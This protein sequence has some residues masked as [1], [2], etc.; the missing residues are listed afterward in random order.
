MEPT[1]GH[2]DS[3]ENEQESA[4]PTEFGTPAAGTGRTGDER[5]VYPKAAGERDPDLAADPTVAGDAPMGQP[6]TDPDSPTP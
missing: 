1:T 4:E 6:T 2:P 3:S 5:L